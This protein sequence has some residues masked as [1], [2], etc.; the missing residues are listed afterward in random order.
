MAQS[1]KQNVQLPFPV[2]GVFESRPY[3]QQPDRTT[4]D[5]K[6]VL[7]FDVSEDKQRGGRRPGLKKI[8]PATEATT[9]RFAGKVQLLD[10]ATVS[11][12]ASTGFPTGVETY[13]NSEEDS[14]FIPAGTPANLTKLAKD[15][16]QDG[17]EDDLVGAESPVVASVAEG[18]PIPVPLFEV[19]SLVP[20]PTSAGWDDNKFITTAT[21]ATSEWNPTK[22]SMIPSGSNIGTS[23][24]WHIKTFAGKDGCFYPKA[25]FD[26]TGN[27]EDH[28]GGFWEDR[29]TAQTVP[30]RFIE[31]M[32]DGENYPYNLFGGGD[33]NSPTTGTYVSSMLFPY[34]SV[35]ENAF[36]SGNGKSWS[37]SANIRTCAEDKLDQTTNNDWPGP[38]V[39]WR[40]TQ[41]QSYSGPDG[42]TDS[43]KL[44]MCWDA[45]SRYLYGFAFRT[46]ASV[47]YS[48]STI[49]A[50]D[51]EQLLFVGFYQ[52]SISTKPQ[53]VISSLSNASAENITLNNT[54][55]LKLPTSDTFDLEW[56]SWYNIEARFDGTNIS[57]YLD[58][59]RLET[60][61]S[62]S[63]FDVS[64][65]VLGEYTGETMDTMRA[66]SG[67]VFWR[68]RTC[69]PFNV[70]VRPN[71]NTG[72]TGDK[73]LF[74]FGI[75]GA[76]GDSSYS[77][78]AWAD[79]DKLGEY[80]PIGRYKY[81]TGSQF[82]GSY[83][84]SYGNSTD[85][86]GKPYLQH[87]V[88]FEMQPGND[89]TQRQQ[90]RVFG[91]ANITSSGPGN[92]GSLKY[93]DDD[94][95][96]SLGDVGS[97]HSSYNNGDNN[98]DNGEWWTSTQMNGVSQADATG[99]VELNTAAKLFFHADHGGSWIR[100]WNEPFFHDVQWR[101]LDVVSEPD[102]VVV[103]VGNGEVK[104][105]SNG[106]ESFSPADQKI[107]EGDNG[108][109]SVV[110][111]PGTRISG[112]EFYSNYYMTDGTKY[113]VLNTTTRELQDWSRLTAATETDDDNETI[114]N[115]SI[116]GGPNFDTDTLKCNLIAQHMGRLVLAGLPSFPNN[117]F[118]S[119]MYTDEISH[120]EGPN[121]W[122]VGDQT[123]SGTGP[124]AGTST[125]LAEIG[126]PIRA[127]F[128]F[129]EDSLIFGCRDSIYVLSGDPGIP[130]SGSSMV[131]ISRD[132]GIVGPD[133][134]AY[135]PNRSLYFFGS[136]GLYSLGPNEFNVNQANRV[137]VGR[138][139]REFSSI[140]IS[141][142]NVR[143]IYDYF[144]Y[145]LHVFMSANTEP[146]GAVRHYFYD[147]R[148]QALWP[149]EYPAAHGPSASVYYSN[150][151]PERR[152]V[153]LGGFDGHVRHFSQYAKN[154]DGVAIDDYVW[155]GP[156]AMDTITESK[157]S[158]IASVLDNTS[159]VVG[160]SIHAGD[161]V[162]EAKGSDP[163][164]T[165]SW[166]SGRNLWQYTRCRGQ[167]IF[168]K[169]Y[170]DEPAEGLLPWS[171]ESITAT[172]AVAGSVR[173]R[174]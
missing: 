152:R 111:Q 126:D 16:N 104:V 129:R 73:T 46:K 105:S 115:Y 155:I 47:S 159:S 112:V 123:D 72:H 11:G 150:A 93:F 107:E 113:G 53:V 54:K 71:P 40:Y 133:A 142:Y 151:D 3:D 160:W 81:T 171:L 102:R 103:G 44:G 99:L 80:A 89:T 127:M 94:I 91:S 132:I 97:Y 13:D 125:S 35:D 172:L 67:L 34:Q 19:T 14:P 70:R 135:G 37:M 4:T 169:L 45:R 39:Q 83:A 69:Q 101:I 55:E 1:P 139:D 68:E 128:N 145:G 148:S 137:S 118:M 27:G 65:I 56:A 64:D 58:D 166:N 17:V 78:V 158:R 28:T 23:N 6:N 66:R 18:H 24:L 144:L 114:G 42:G 22:E 74:G 77:S 2:N 41:P 82:V 170:T 8:T 12:N 157:L 136:N 52:S 141:K 87:Q 90:C 36:D 61:D 110:F 25:P 38:V 60:E 7:A 85:Y 96:W 108:D 174:N 173:E 117:W 26:L 153:L 146:T 138:L 30:H 131:A 167:S 33:T 9:D 109:R 79:I 116:P 43:F 140:D 120:G 50:T 57:V 163:V 86:G 165:G 164:A 161:T 168:V 143:L 75:T 63:K 21:G 100:D 29:K 130:E 32:K 51:D 162:E 62:K 88:K 156:F 48:D 98:R 15:P 122:D 49:T 59:T 76:V 119:A 106:A 92:L 134:W 124:V 84:Q 5:A 95:T 121:N 31:S 147:L 149:M 154:D 10:L 20:K